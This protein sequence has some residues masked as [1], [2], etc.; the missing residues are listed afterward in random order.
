M[1][2]MDVCRRL[3]R[4][5][6]MLGLLATLGLGGCAAF[7]TMNVEVSSFGSWPAER[8]VGTYAFDR[9]P[10]QQAKAEDQ[11]NLEDMA[12]PALEEAGFTAA[13]EGQK[14]DVLVQIGA[15]WDR[16][17]RSPWDDPLWMHPWGPRWRMTPWAGPGWGWGYY[18]PEYTRE[19][20]VLI[21]DRESGAALYESRASTNGSTTGGRSLFEAMFLAAMKEFPAVD[22]KPH[23][24]NVTLP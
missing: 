12:R 3:G 16:A 7:N 5:A 6:V 11:Q 21:R 1:R 24:V 10:S 20:A 23:V 13:A 8:H 2:A 17:D 19:V 22:G 14:P 15:R 18:Q 4:P 9:L